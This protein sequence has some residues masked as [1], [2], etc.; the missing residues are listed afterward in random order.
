M[1]LSSKGWF[2]AV[3]VAL[4][5]Q[6]SSCRKPPSKPEPARNNGPSAVARVP[7][8]APSAK[9]TAAADGNLDT[10][11]R[12]FALSEAGEAFISDNVVSNET[13]LLQPASAL[14]SLQGGAYIGVGPEQNF[15]YIALSRPELAVV[16][17]LRRDNA[18]LHL[19]YKSLFDLA[20]SRLEFLCVLLGRPYDP[21]F[22]P[23]IDSHVDALLAS[24][25]GIT[26]TRDWFD[27]QHARLVE[28]I[29]SYNLNLSDT[30]VA[31]IRH[32]HELFFERQLDLRFELRK[33]NGRRYPSYKQLLALRSVSGVGTFLD[34]RESAARWWLPI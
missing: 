21:K 17:D 15:T 6:S 18:L 1:R 8:P 7:R 26:P 16:I 32:V 19:L 13:S 34:S 9:G 28:R 24:V 12:L 14:A 27:Q 31:R 29:R 33:A 30:D 20:A 22:E 4:A 10:F 25:A 2:R 23:S 11:R 5:I 3:C